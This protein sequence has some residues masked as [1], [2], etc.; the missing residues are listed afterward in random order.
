MFKYRRTKNGSLCKSIPIES[1]GIFIGDQTI[2]E[3]K[4]STGKNFLLNFLLTHFNKH[5]ERISELAGID[6]KLNNK[7]ARKTF[8][9]I[10]C[11]DRKLPVHL[12][13]ILLGHQNVKHT[14]HYLRIDDVD[15]A[16]QVKQYM[17]PALI[18]Q[19]VFIRYIFVY[20]YNK[21]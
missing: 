2:K 13:Q 6:F 16:S 14:L 9:S 19:P 12:L 15:H 3:Y 5:P 20:S 10:L 17:F 8:A 11:F 7:M 1:E 4:L 21:L 18:E